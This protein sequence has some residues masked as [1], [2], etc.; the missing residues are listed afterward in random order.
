MVTYEQWERGNLRG[1][2]ARFVGNDRD[3]D[4]NAVR[5]FE[6]DEAEWGTANDKAQREYEFKYVQWHQTYHK[7]QRDSRCTIC[8]AEGEFAAIR[9]PHDENHRAT[10]RYDPNCRFCQ[11]DR[12]FG[13]M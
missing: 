4:G 2:P 9:Q 12:F 3:A 13:R 8:Q 7:N 11:D 6:V 1:L 10:G 5:V